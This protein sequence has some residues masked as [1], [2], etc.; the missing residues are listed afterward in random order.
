MLLMDLTEETGDDNNSGATD[1]QAESDDDE[2]TNDDDD[3]ERRPAKRAKKGKDEEETAHCDIHYVKNTTYSVFAGN[4]KK[5]WGTVKAVDPAPR[6]ATAR[7]EEYIPGDYL[8]VKG[9]AITLKHT[10]SN[11]TKATFD[12]EEELI[13]TSEWERFDDQMTG[14]DLVDLDDVTF[15]IWW[16]NI[17]PPPVQ[18]PKKK[19]KKS[20]R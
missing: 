10:G 18:K 1:V 5:V 14:Q 3:A 16:Q 13:L 8:L 7:K 9:N 4:T 12:P 17:K 6:V 15:L 2:H 20:G 19:A 11:N